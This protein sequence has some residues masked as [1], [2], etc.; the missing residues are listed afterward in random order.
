MLIATCEICKPIHHP[1]FAQVPGTRPNDHIASLSLWNGNECMSGVAKTSNCLTS[2]CDGMMDHLRHVLHE[3][4]RLVDSV[5][6]HERKHVRLPIMIR[7]LQGDKEAAT[8]HRS[9]TIDG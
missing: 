1:L 7:R 4:T 3:C 9:C 6:N 2:G 5:L 8:N